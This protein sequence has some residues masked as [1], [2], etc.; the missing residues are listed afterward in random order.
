MGETHVQAELVQDLRSELEQLRTTIAAAEKADKQ[1]A[2]G[3]VK[4]LIATRLEILRTTEALVQQRMLAIESGAPVTLCVPTT[5]PDLKKAM[6]L[7]REIANEEKKLSSSQAEMARYSGG[8]V[9][10]LK[11][12]AVATQEQTLAMLQQNMLTAKYGLAFPFSVTQGNGS[13][14]TATKATIPIA[15][16]NGQEE[17]IRVTLLRKNLVDNHVLAFDLEFTGAGLQKAS[18]A[19]KGWLCLKDLFGETRLRIAW[20]I[21]QTLIPGRFVS[22]RGLGFRY[23]QFME[24]HQWVQRT[25]V[26]DVVVAFEI[27]HILYQDGT[28]QDF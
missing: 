16:D 28:R 4:A 5:Q 1:F 19:I 15:P 24:N 13:V 27:E 12:T 7:E 17:L 26:T 8:L 6:E 11:L 21:D 10:S 3:L 25:A 18:R 23:N 22:S 2:G 20:T 14:D 9:H